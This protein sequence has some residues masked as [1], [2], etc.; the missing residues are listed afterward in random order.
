MGKMPNDFVP[1]KYASEAS[2]G[3]NNAMLNFFIG[4][5]FIMFMI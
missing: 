5:L 4:G 3:Q 2:S 1:V